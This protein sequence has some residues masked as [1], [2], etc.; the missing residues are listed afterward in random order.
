MIVSFL[1]KIETNYISLHSF[2]CKSKEDIH[3]Y[4][5]KYITFFFQIGVSLSNRTPSSCPERIDRK[6]ERNK[7]LK[8]YI[9]LSE[10]D[11]QASK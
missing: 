2:L 9:T 8:K 7:S 1:C 10:T 4:K 11:K 3:Y 5:N 6:T